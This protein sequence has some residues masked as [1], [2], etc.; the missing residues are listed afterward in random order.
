MY[1]YM[2]VSVNCLLKSLR[3]RGTEKL[4]RTHTI[5]RTALYLYTYTYTYLQS[6][7]LY[8]LFLMRWTFNTYYDHI[9]TLYKR[10]LTLWV[11]SKSLAPKED[12]KR[13]TGR[14]HE[15]FFH[16]STARDNFVHRSICS[17]FQL[18]SGW[19]TRHWFHWKLESTLPVSIGEE[20]SWNIDHSGHRW[21]D[22]S[23]YSSH[24]WSSIWWD[25]VSESGSEWKWERAEWDACI[26]GCLSKPIERS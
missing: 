3:E 17:F 23:I 16:L 2:N 26:D 9:C 25:E 21:K 13:L 5:W 7:S 8:I 18:P 11:F 19:T 22:N 14:H 24:S 6:L 1:S 12:G 4:A 20:S 15:F 10:Q